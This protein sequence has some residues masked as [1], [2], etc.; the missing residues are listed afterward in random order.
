MEY[1]PTNLSPSHDSRVK[2]IVFKCNR[3]CWRTARPA[4]VAAGCHLIPL[5]ISTIFQHR[6]L[7][8]AEMFFLSKLLR[9]LLRREFFTLWNLWNN[10]HSKPQ[11]ATSPARHQRLENWRR[12]WS[13]SM[14]RREGSRLCCTNTTKHAVQG[15]RHV[16]LCI[17]K[18]VVLADLAEDEV[19]PHSFFFTEMSS[20]S[21]S[22]QNRTIPTAHW[23]SLLGKIR[24]KEGAGKGIEESLFFCERDGNRSII[25]H[26]KMFESDSLDSYTYSCILVLLNYPHFWPQE[27]HCM[28]HIWYIW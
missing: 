2:P 16:C 9:K 25:N 15:K 19:K 4:T 21:G 11:Q 7:V 26:R 18:C 24:R 20:Q 6:Q 23:C 27:T 8:M 3:C 14:E 13:K 28:F 1:T 12:H 5:I 17:K 10:I 22:F